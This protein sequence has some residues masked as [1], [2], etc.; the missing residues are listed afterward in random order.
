MPD[1]FW[2][3]AHQHSSSFLKHRAIRAQTRI[4]GG[5]TNRRAAS[6]G[7]KS[8]PRRFLDDTTRLKSGDRRW[9]HDLEMSTHKQT[10]C[11]LPS[12]GT[13][14]HLE[15]NCRLLQTSSGNHCVCSASTNQPFLNASRQE[16]SVP[17]YNEGKMQEGKKRSNAGCSGY[18]RKKKK[19][20]R[21][22]VC[23]FFLSF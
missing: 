6:K 15:C 1:G 21:L 17:P 11:Y 9:C 8:S 23:V 12:R 19:K 10:A 3:R 16:Y 7:R 5:C 2:S 22:F 13:Y 18:S 20:L 14:G 4:R